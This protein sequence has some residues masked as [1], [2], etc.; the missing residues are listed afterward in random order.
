MM[1]ITNSPCLRGSKHSVFG[2]RRHVVGLG[3]VDTPAAPK[4]GG[5]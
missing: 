4:H 3:K 2:R 1:D 5:K